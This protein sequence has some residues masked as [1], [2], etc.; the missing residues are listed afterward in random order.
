MQD[1]IEG[2]Q[3]YSGLIV[4]L[5]AGLARTMGEAGVGRLRAGMRLSG[6]P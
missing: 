4:R 5:L 1:L 6:D 3:S 2:S